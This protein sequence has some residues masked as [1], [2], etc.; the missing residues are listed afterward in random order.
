MLESSLQLT[1]TSNSWFGAVYQSSKRMNGMTLGR[2]V[3]CGRFS[4]AFVILPG[5][6]SVINAKEARHGVNQEVTEARDSRSSQAAAVFRGSWGRLRCATRQS[7][8]Q[9][10][11]GEAARQRF[12]SMPSRVKRSSKLFPNWDAAE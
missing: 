8:E 12:V 10:V 6:C 5:K 9:G 2:W 3:N 11:Q 1:R 4:L 7:D